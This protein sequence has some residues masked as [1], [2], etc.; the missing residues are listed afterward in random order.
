MVTTAPKMGLR[1]KRKAETRERIVKAAIDCFTEHGFNGAST[2][3]I[4]KAAGVGQGL[5][6]YHFESK[7]ALWKIAVSQV[8]DSIPT[9]PPF[10]PDSV[11]TKQDAK[12]AL[13][14]Y[15]RKFAEDCLNGP[16]VAMFL[17]HQGSQPDDK[18]SWMLDEHLT[19]S[20]EHM[21]PLYDAALRVKAIKPIPFINFSFSVLA[22]VNTHF[23]LHNVYQHIS[24]EDPKD[25]ST[26]DKLLQTILEMLTEN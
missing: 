25:A 10:D 1:E 14:A 17:Y 12:T 24:G 9:P 19:P 8:Y 16:N 20:L 18:L 11:K 4:A 13:L 2:R 15:L 6:T 21:R 5:V 7:E 22:V 26:A 23:A 3:D